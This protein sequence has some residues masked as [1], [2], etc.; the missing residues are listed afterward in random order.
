MKPIPPAI[1][2]DFVTVLPSRVTETN[3][4]SCWSKSST[5]L[6][7]SASDRVRRVAGLDGAIAAKWDRGRLPRLEFLAPEAEPC[8]RD[9]HEY[10]QQRADECG[11]KLTT[12]RLTE[13]QWG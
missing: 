7:K 1:A 2:V 9:G 10:Q 12:R 5:S 3:E 11:C 8:Q 6:A 4:T 13:W